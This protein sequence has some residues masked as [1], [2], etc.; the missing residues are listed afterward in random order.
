MIEKLFER[1]REIVE[2]GGPLPPIANDDWYRNEVEIIKDL[3]HDGLLSY[4]REFFPVFAPV[5][6]ARSSVD[7]RRLLCYLA[8]SQLRS[9]A[10]SGMDL[11]LFALAGAQGKAG[12]SPI[13]VD[14]PS[15]A[16]FAR[17]RDWVLLK[18]FS[19]PRKTTT[20]AKYIREMFDTTMTHHH[21]LMVVMGFLRRMGNDPLY[22]VRWRYASMAGKTRVY[23]VQRAGSVEW[24]ID[25]DEQALRRE[26]KKSNRADHRGRGEARGQRGDD[27]G[28]R[29][30]VDLQRP[31]HGEGEAGGG[32]EESSEL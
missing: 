6:E 31:E 28:A 13:V 2:E 9:V 16:D 30:S 10:A 19:K 14:M 11:D 15:E 8:L 12:S 17:P 27:R 7:A 32:G 1:R 26:R 29:E 20:A 25:E 21:A 23:Q 3:D 18:L 24:S 22:E 4:A 5:I